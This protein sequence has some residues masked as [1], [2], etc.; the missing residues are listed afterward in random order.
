MENLKTFIFE[1]TE[2]EIK[3]IVELLGKKN[4]SHVSND[5]KRYLSVLLAKAEEEEDRLN[6]PILKNEKFL[7][8]AIF[9]GTKLEQMAKETKFDYSIYSDGDAD[10]RYDASGGN[11]ILNQDLFNIPESKYY[12]GDRRTIGQIMEWEELELNTKTLRY[13]GDY[14]VN[15]TVVLNKIK[16][17]E[18][19]N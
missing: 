11:E 7:A 17:I 3:E 12:A 8:D 1:G 5:E 2:E 14:V 15:E 9:Y 18:M 4:I 13:G 10:I 16:T 6:Q 19:G